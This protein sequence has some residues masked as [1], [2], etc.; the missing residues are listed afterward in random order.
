MVSQG[1]GGCQEPGAGG[2]TVPEPAWQAPA[3]EFLDAALNSCGWTFTRVLQVRSGFQNP[4]K[5]PKHGKPRCP[6][7]FWCVGDGSARIPGKAPAGTSGA[8]GW[9]VLPWS[10][11]CC[12]L[13]PVQAIRDPIFAGNGPSEEEWVAQAGMR[14]I[15]GVSMGQSLDGMGRSWQPH[16]LGF[17]LLHRA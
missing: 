11:P 2:E 17:S 9:V 8:A 12:Q 16:P 15:L 13:F 6:W 3:V 10:S 4:L 1:P 14:G 5:P 7:E